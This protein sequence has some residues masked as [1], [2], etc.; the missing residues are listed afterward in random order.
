MPNID[1]QCH[2]NAIA[3]SRTHCYS[4]LDATG[5]CGGGPLISTSSFL[6][7]RIGW[8]R[9]ATFAHISPT[10]RHRRAAVI[11]TNRH[12]IRWLLVCYLSHHPKTIYSRLNSRHAMAPL[13]HSISAKHLLKSKQMCCCAQISY[14]KFALKIA[15]L[16]L[17]AIS[18]WSRH[19]ISISHTS[20]AAA[21]ASA[22]QS[23]RAPTKKCSCQQQ[24]KSN[25]YRPLPN[26]SNQTRQT[27][28][29]IISEARSGSSF[30]GF[31][32]L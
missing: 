10:C 22:G 1:P 19:H 23:S 11:G 28:I 16:L 6:I 29:L 13:L 8:A 25:Y 4:V 18:L 31:D 24:A 15:F 30:L 27:R 17:I 7:E 32:L 5:G 20:A 3:V 21:V 26:R 12:L 9:H 14:R 2:R